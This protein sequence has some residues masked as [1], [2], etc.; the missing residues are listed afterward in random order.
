MFPVGP[1]ARQPVEPG[2]PLG[3]LTRLLVELSD[4]PLFLIKPA[5]RAKPAKLAQPAN[6]A[7]LI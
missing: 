7:Q 5:Q 6:P 1:L 2:S 3:L 4:L